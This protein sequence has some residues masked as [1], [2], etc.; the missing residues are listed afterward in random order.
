MWKNEKL[1][2]SW[3]FEV[4]IH[5][6]EEERNTIQYNTIQYNTIQY[7][8]IQYRTQ[9]NFSKIG[10]V[11]KQEVTT[12]TSQSVLYVRASATHRILFPSYYLLCFSYIFPLIPNTLSILLSSFFHLRILFYLQIENL[13]WYSRIYSLKSNLY[14]YFH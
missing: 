3:N 5:K 1:K 11:I 10:I 6:R 12:M 9:K 4:K 2:K 8:T 13:F 7:N 14:F